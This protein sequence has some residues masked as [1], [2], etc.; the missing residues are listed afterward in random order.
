MHLK[1]CSL[2]KETLEKPF[3]KEFTTKECKHR[4]SSRKMERRL[5]KT[6]PNYK[7]FVK[8]RFTQKSCAAG[9]KKLY[10]I[11]CILQSEKAEKSSSEK[12][13]SSQKKPSSK[14]GKTVKE[15]KTLKIKK[16][17]N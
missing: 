13:S 8:K 2:L 3:F 7:I 11:D 16:N 5:R 15:K 14:Q 10:Y 6:I 1:H 9:L 4:A 17:K 12:K